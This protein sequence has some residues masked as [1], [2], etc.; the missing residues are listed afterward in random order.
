MALPWMRKTPTEGSSMGPWKTCG[1]V[2]ADDVDNDNAVAVEKR[3]DVDVDDVDIGVSD[4]W[5]IS[6][7]LSSPR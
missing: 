5:G 2:D 6:D 4:F 7:G 3:V 1:K